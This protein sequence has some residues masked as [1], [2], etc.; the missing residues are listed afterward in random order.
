M[1][2]FADENVA[3]AIIRCYVKLATTC[4]LPLNQHQERVTRFGCA[5][6]SRKNV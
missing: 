5:E 4:F 3:Y 1:R 2:L 6:L